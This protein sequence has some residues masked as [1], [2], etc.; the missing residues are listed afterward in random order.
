LVLALLDEDDEPRLPVPASA[1]PSIAVAASR[2]SFPL[3]LF[4]VQPVNSAAE[5]QSTH[6]P[7]RENTL[8]MAANV[9][10]VAPRVYALQL[11]ASAFK[12]RSC[13]AQEPH[14]G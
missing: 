1:E 9:S 7:P 11:S 2:A 8:D 6:N 12:P 13:T 3:S 4:E 14:I 10:K 5:P